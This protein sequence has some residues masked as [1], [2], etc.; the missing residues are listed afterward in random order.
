M[1][2]ALSSS[3]MSVL[4]RATRRN[5]AD[6][7]ILHVQFLFQFGISDLDLF[8]SFPTGRPG[9]EPRLGHVGFVVDEATLE[10]VFSKYLSF[11]CQTSTDFSTRIAIH[12]HPGLVEWTI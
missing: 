7:A 4:T 1:K 8:N 10:Q 6:G 11:P 2:A 3:E 12:Y 5:I 9:F